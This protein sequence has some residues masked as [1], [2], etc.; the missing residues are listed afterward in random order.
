M[1]YRFTKTEKWISD[2]WFMDLNAGQKLFFLYLCENCDCTGIWEINIR[3]ASYRI[4]LNEELV[5][6]AFKAI[7]RCYFTDGQA[8]AL[9]TFLYHQRCLPLN[10]DNPA[11]RGILRR[12]AEHSALFQQLQTYWAQK[13][14]VSCE[15]PLFESYQQLI[16]KGASKPLQRGYG[17]GNGK[18]NGKSNGKGNGKGNSNV[19]FDFTNRIW[20]GIT[21]EDLKQ[22]KAAFPAVDIET[23]L[24]SAAQ[25]AFDNPNKKKKNWRRF[26]TNWF[27][28]RQ[29][30][31]GNIYAHSRAKYNR[32][33][34]DQRSSIGTVI[35]MPD[36][37]P[38]KTV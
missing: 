16:H 25:W 9:K 11:H 26:L 34:A 37:Q 14:Y 2:K 29:E 10:K 12:L 17:K 20:T 35:Q 21:E 28:R 4:G 3:D 5:Y 36:V 7:E 19:Q 15:L 38:A 6:E 31:G 18:G 27:C 13:G 23:E 1:P 32:Q 30:K 22:W 24:K 33:Y 8:I